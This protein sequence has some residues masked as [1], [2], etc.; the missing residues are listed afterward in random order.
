MSD[1]LTVLNVFKVLGLVALIL[2]FRWAAIERARLRHQWIRSHEV[3][4][5]LRVF[6]IDASAT[7]AV[8]TAS[9]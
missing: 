3:I 6:F 9:V 4:D 1:W 2:L 5:R 7:G 8:L